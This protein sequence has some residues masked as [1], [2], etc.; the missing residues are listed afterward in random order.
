MLRMLWPH[1]DKKFRLC[2]QYLDSLVVQPTVS[3]VFRFHVIR[4]RGRMPPASSYRREKFRHLGLHVPLVL[5]HC[6]KP[7]PLMAKAATI[8]AV[9]MVFPFLEA[10]GRKNDDR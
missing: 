1:P 4:L 8:R 9:M 10:A 5:I 7:D 3:G 6:Q 2:P